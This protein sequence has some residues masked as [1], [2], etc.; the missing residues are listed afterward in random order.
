MK[1]ARNL[2]PSGKAFSRLEIRAAGDR[3]PVVLSP[4]TRRMISATLRGADRAAPGAPEEPDVTISGVL[5]ALDLDKDWLEVTSGGEHHRVVNVAETVDDVIGP[6]VN[7]DVIVRVRRGKRGL[8][9]IDIEP[10]E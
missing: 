9:F 10:D 7:R 6:M 8:T 3:R 2:S 4:E 5:R 1:M